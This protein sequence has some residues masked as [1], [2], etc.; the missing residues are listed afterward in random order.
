MV[1]LSLVSSLDRE[2]VADWDELNAIFKFVESM[3]EQSYLINATKDVDVRLFTSIKFIWF[4]PQTSAREANLV[5]YRS[6][7]R[8]RK[9]IKYLLGGRVVVVIVTNVVVGNSVASENSVGFSGEVLSACPSIFSV[10]YRERGRKSLIS[11]RVSPTYAEKEDEDEDPRDVHVDWCLSTN[12]SSLV[13]KTTKTGA[14][15]LSVCEIFFRHVW[16]QK[17]SGGGE[18]RQPVSEWER[19][20]RY[21]NDRHWTSNRRSF[22]KYFSRDISRKPSFFRFLPHMRNGEVRNVCRRRAL[23]GILS[24]E[25]TADLDESCSLE[26]RIIKRS[27]QALRVI[28]FLSQL[29]SREDFLDFGELSSSEAWQRGSIWSGTDNIDRA[30]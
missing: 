12:T 11:I 3:K 1:L 24:N 13:K 7:L 25:F 26:G 14:F 10:I 19:K 30:D 6:A 2:Q 29:P 4:L 20:K 27:R 16:E 17:T 18:L 23:S 8:R 5:R 22:S 15:L 9:K 21:Q 28:P